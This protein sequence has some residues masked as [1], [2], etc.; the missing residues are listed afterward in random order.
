MSAIKT[1]R[2]DSPQEHSI[3]WNAGAV[4][5]KR[6]GWVAVATENYCFN[7]GEYQGEGTYETRD[8][9]DNTRMGPWVAFMGR[10]L[11]PTLSAFESNGSRWEYD[12][13]SI[14]QTIDHGGVPYYV[15]EDAR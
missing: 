10:E 6:L 2:L 14:T 4:Y 15:V 3:K 11:R 5:Y 1:T 9:C 8:H 12:K 7:D 13:V